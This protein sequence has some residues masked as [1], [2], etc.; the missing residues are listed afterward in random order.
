MEAF[1]ERINQGITAKE[2]LLLHYGLYGKKMSFA[3]ISEC[4]KL[5]VER[6]SV[7]EMKA[8]HSLRISDYIYQL[9]ERHG[10]EFGITVERWKEAMVSKQIPK[11]IAEKIE[12]IDD[13]LNSF[14]KGKVGEIA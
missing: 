14:F 5:S 4:V 3:Q 12:N 2:V 10:D 7:I 6:L 11:V 9:I 13:L 1:T 8:M